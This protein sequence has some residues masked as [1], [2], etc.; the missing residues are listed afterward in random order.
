MCVRRKMFRAEG[1]E[2]IRRIREDLAEV[3]SPPAEG[4]QREGRVSILKVGEVD[5]GKP[6]LDEDSGH[7]LSSIRGVRA[8]FSGM[9]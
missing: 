5:W 3:F 9:M 2:K 7:E 6:E 4:K 8:G 1:V